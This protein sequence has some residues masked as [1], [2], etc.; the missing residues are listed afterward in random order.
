M[1][2]TSFLLLPAVL[3]SVLLAAAPAAPDQAG[4]SEAVEEQRSCGAEADP[5]YDPPSGHGL[6]ECTTDGAHDPGKTYTATY[7]T[8]DV[9]CGTDDELAPGAHGATGVSVSGDFAQD[10]TGGAGYLQTCSD[11]ALP[12]QGRFTL[13][14]VV[15]AGG[16]D[17]TFTADGDRDN[18]PDQL[19]GWAQVDVGDRTVTCGPSYDE[20]GRADAYN[21]AEGEGSQEHC[22]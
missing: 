18:S 13:D 11:G 16:A 2:T 22:G 20:G 19:Q 15:G 9:T 17:G 5:H 4:S 10:G 8:N 6:D 21:Q 1:R 7:Y 12:I 3:A 14:G